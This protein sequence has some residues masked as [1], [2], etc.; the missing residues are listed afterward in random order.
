M[1]KKIYSLIA[2]LTLVLFLPMQVWAV[3]AKPVTKR[4]MVGDTEYSVF[5]QGD[6]FCH[7]WQAETGEK[8]VQRQDG[9]YH[10]LS[11]FET[12][13]MFQQASQAR[14]AVNGARASKQH[15][16]LKSLTGSK[17]GL[18]ILVNFKDLSFSVTNPSPMYNQ[19]FN[20]LNYTG[21]GMTGSV[22]DYFRAQSYG[23]FDLTLDV[24]GPYTLS[25][26]MSQYG[27]NDANGSDVGVQAFARES[28]QLA[29]KDVNY[30]DYD[31]DGDGVVEQVFIVYAGYAEAQGGPAN[32]I[33]PHSWS[34]PTALT[35]DG[36]KVS[37]YA[38]S[39][40]L[41]GGSGEDID[42][43]GTICHEFSHCLGLMDHYDTQGN[44]FGMSYWDL[45]AAGSYLNNSC[46]PAAYTSFERWCMGWLTP[47]ELNSQTDING[48]KSLVD[49]PEAY[50][51]Y[52]DANPNEFYM[53]ENRQ[54]KGFDTYLYGHGLLVLHVDYDQMVWAYN[55]VNTSAARQRVTIIPADG[56]QANTLKSLQADP[57]PG[58]LGVKALT[59]NTLP[60][61]SL[62][63]NNADGRKF[64]SKPIEDIVENNGLISFKALY[65]SLSAP[66]PKATSV[67]EGS[68]TLTWP[69]VAHADS[70]ELQLTEYGGKQSPQEALVLEETFAN[71]YKSTNGFS[72]IGS[73][74]SD[75]LDNKGFSGTSLFQSPHKLLFGTSTTNGT[76]MSPVFGT[77]STARFT[78]VL[79]V[80]PYAAGKAVA[81]VVNVVTEHSNGMNIPFE[82][83]EEGYILLYPTENIGSRFYVD[84]KPES[85]MYLS[86]MA[87]YD[88]EFTAEE[89]GLNAQARAKAGAYKTT[90]YKTNEPKYVFTGLNPTA[91]YEVIVRA[92]EGSR[93]SPWS[94][95]CVVSLATGI[96]AISQDDTNGVPVYYD[97]QGRKVV[98]PVH[99]NIYICNGRK[100]MY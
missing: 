8:I 70:Y 19:I 58:T 53:L 41:R 4:V 37:Q 65:P 47:R 15:G 88:G 60:A 83:K 59:D 27:G 82:F 61:A 29:N 36:V 16:F 30:K 80:K 2:C 68:F 21:Y 12:E 99:G 23:V 92:L 87:V 45:M 63:N 44:N 81:G 13:N 64:M 93:Q 10:I 34:L 69:A 74:L 40:E 1:R 22:R 85:R 72:N 50:I 67:G 3:P 100:V 32:S 49:S 25:G 97:L 6:E 14:T 78:L 9:R 54:K 56:E 38:C 26:N 84:I 86:Y 89:L 11:Y 31:W 77:L 76:L 73:K 94:D 17:R 20:E 33:W 35:L 62:Y 75:Y 57:F 96:D 90:T 42:G 52:N 43:I 18:V 46:T 95:V 66:A 48:M 28:F 79:K 91:R 7:Y 39:S 98:Y 5:L 71:T 24:A 55:Q 51:L